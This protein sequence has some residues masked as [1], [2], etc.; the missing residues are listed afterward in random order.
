VKTIEIRISGKVQKVGMRNCIRRIAVKLSVKGE[1]M[2]LPDG[3]VK[4]YASGDQMLLDKFVSMIYGCPRAI[5]RDL[6][7]QDHE[8]LAFEDFSVRK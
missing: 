8:P 7:I 4:A 1:V 2:N 5:I 3:T 6:K